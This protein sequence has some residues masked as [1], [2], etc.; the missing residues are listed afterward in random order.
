MPPVRYYQVDAVGGRDNS[1][2]DGLS[3]LPHLGGFFI[4]TR[5]STSLGHPGLH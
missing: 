2:T 4:A 3:N 5:I 1:P